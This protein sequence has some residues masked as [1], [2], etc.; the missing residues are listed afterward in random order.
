MACP[1]CGGAL[2]SYQLGD[3]ETVVCRDCVYVGI[4]VDH[5]ADGGETESWDD[6]LDRFHAQHETAAPPADDTGRDSDDRSVTDQT[7]PSDDPAESG[8][9]TDESADDSRSETSE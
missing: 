1:R 6:A 5:T 9:E 8:P 2:I 4:T 7:D 3:A